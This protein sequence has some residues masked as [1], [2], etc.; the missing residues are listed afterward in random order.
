MST[1]PAAG[2]ELGLQVDEHGSWDVAPGVFGAPAVMIGEVPPGVEHAGVRRGRQFGDRNE[3]RRRHGVGSL[4]RVGIYGAF[5]GR[6]GRP[7]YLFAEFAE[8]L[9]HRRCETGGGVLHLR[10]NLGVAHGGTQRVENGLDRGPECLQRGSNV[11]LGWAV[12]A[13][14]LGVLVAQLVSDVR[15]AL[16]GGA[17]GVPWF[18]RIVCVFLHLLDGTYELFRSYYGV[19]PRTAPDGREVGAI[20][21]IIDSTLAL[22]TDPDVTHAAVATDQVIESFRNDMF[23]GY[24]TGAGI[25]PALWAQF[26]LA[27]RA[28]RALGVTLWSMVEFEADDAIATAAARWKDDVDE[29][30]ILTPDKDLMQMVDGHRVVSFNRRERK[31]LAEEDVFEKFGVSPKSIPDY[32]ALVGD[33]ADGVPGLP[34]WG[35]K[36]ASTILARYEHIEAIPSDADEWDVTVRGASKLAATLVERMDDALLFRELTTL[37]L[38]VPITESLED[39]RWIGV[40]GPRFEELCVELGFENLLERDLPRR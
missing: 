34:G 30:V 40:D 7:A 25:E 27:D 26:P 12:V 17:P 31:R 8:G 16:G 19:P 22:L 24:K 18:P 10:S 14:Q 35:A 11:V 37:R 29:V 9:A 23:E 13:D 20:R 1:G 2:A 28:F 39:L 32:L 38:D 21:G 33:T 3:R 4:F 5:G 15:P 6:P 36:S